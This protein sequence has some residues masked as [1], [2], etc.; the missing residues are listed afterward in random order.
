MLT[1]GSTES[2]EM[3]KKAEE[4]WQKH[5]HKQKLWHGKSLERPRKKDFGVALKMSCQTF[6]TSGG[7]VETMHEG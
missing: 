1:E 2:V 3:Y 4:L 6:G 7:K 5:L